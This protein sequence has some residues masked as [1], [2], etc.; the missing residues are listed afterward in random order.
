MA[1]AVRGYSEDEFDEEDKL[2]QQAALSAAGY[3]HASSLLQ[4]KQSALTDEINKIS[5]EYRHINQMKRVM[6][7][8]NVCLGEL[9][10]HAGRD[11]NY[12]IRIFFL[13]N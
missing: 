10:K 13:H 11:V 1:L 6:R 8:A 5:A 12:G 7:E 4:S 2:Q 3:I 9:L